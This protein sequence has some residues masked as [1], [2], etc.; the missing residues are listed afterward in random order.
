MND[1][2]RER[3]DRMLDAE[4]QRK[5]EQARQV[6]AERRQVQEAHAAWQR[7]LSNV[8]TPALK[9]FQERLKGAPYLAVVREP[10]QLSHRP[11]IE[12]VLPET[13]LR[14]QEFLFRVTER[15]IH[16]TFGSGTTEPVALSGA[17]TGDWISEQVLGWLEKALDL[18]ER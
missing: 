13:P 1:E 17:V 6:A 7:L 4:E 10:D 11:G 5:A 9:A 2:Q 18:K 3:L 14:R 12:L 8:V 16:S 15:G